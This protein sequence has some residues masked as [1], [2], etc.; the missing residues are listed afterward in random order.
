MKINIDDEN[1]MKK[2]E[3]KELGLLIKQYK[4]GTFTKDLLNMKDKTLQL[5]SERGQ[6]L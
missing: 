1:Y 4:N 2:E 5:S 6:G 3:G